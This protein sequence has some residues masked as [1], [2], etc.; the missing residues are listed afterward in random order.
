MP[1]LGKLS[2]QVVS[3][4]GASPIEDATI[5]IS[6]TGNPTNTLE[7]LIT[8][9]SG[10]ADTIELPSPPLEYSVSPSEVQP[11]SEYTLTLPHPAIRNWSS[12]VPKYCRM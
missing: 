9:D 11:Y 8:N 4:V 2:V 5:S 6:Y 12:A 10:F 7:Q 1:D 3:S